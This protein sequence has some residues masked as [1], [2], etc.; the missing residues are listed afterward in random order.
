MSIVPAYPPPSHE[1]NRL[2][3][4]A[5]WRMTVNEG[6]IDCIREGGTNRVVYPDNMTAD[7]R[8]ID[9]MASTES[10]SFPFVT[11]EQMDFAR[12]LNLRERYGNAQGLSED[13]YF[14][15]G[16]PRIKASK[17]IPEVTSTGNHSVYG[18]VSDFGAV[19]EQNNNLLTT[20][21]TRNYMNQRKLGGV[22]KMNY[23][24]R[25]PTSDGY[26]LASHDDVEVQRING[27]REEWRP[28]APAPASPVPRL[29]LHSIQEEFNHNTGELTGRYSTDRTYN[30]SGYPSDRMPNAS[31][32]PFDRMSSLATYSNDRMRHVSAYP[33]EGMPNHS[34]YRSDRLQNGTAP[35]YDGREPTD[36]SFDGFNDSS[37]PAFNVAEIVH[38]FDRL[39]DSST[40]LDNTREP[41]EPNMS[42]RWYENQPA[43]SY[44]TREVTDRYSHVRPDTSSAPSYREANLNFTSN[45]LNARETNAQD[46]TKNL[47][48][49]GSPPYYNGDAGD[50]YTSSSQYRHTSPP[51]ETIDRRP[52]NVAR[53]TRYSGEDVYPP[54]SPDREA[55]RYSPRSSGYSP[56]PAS[57][58]KRELP[59]LIGPVRQS[60]SPPAQV[61][62]QHSSPPLPPNPTRGGVVSPGYRDKMRPTNMFSDE[63]AERMKRQAYYDWTSPT[64][65]KYRPAFPSRS[66]Y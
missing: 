15:F 39:Q 40:T 10:T 47:P 35:D 36:R 52:S 65:E 18:S 8:S 32:Y 1:T 12:K 4:W 37:L 25:G 63:E 51:R 24:D 22:E 7:S 30:T 64:Q 55:A 48:S 3:R 60:Y 44:N 6:I 58:R 31:G 53:N 16:L 23:S 29:N 42:N 66:I 41:A 14:I 21:T 50:H 13:S 33:S 57:P 43:Q 5:M 17:D 61:S 19:M 38:R 2:H 26:L 11:A 34:A 20:A 59:P 9:I 49:P 56:P 27:Y 45:Q 28:P 54:F 62:S 46:Y